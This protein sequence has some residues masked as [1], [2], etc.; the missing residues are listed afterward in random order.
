MIQTQPRKLSFEEYLKYEDDTENRYELMNGELVPLP[1]ESELNDSIANYLLF[2]LA[3]RGWV[4]LRQIRTH[5]C[6]LQVPILQAGDAANRYPD[7]VVLAQEHLT[8]TEK[9]LTI[10]LE[11]PPPPLV[12]EVVSPGRERDYEQKRRQYAVRG[13]REYWILDRHEQTA[14]VL[15]LDSASLQYRDRA[16]RGSDRLISPTFPQFDLTAEQVLAAGEL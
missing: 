1:H 6:E 5:T 2:A 4:P 13:I 7:L 9:R 10:L 15:Y 3:S 11:M 8:L 16:F 12:V 14:I